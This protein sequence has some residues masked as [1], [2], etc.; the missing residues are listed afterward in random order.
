MDEVRVSS[1]FLHPRL[2]NYGTEAVSNRH[3]LLGFQSAA[4]RVLLDLSRL[5]EGVYE[6]VDRASQT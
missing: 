1:I 3:S 2:Y 6:I 5:G 4:I